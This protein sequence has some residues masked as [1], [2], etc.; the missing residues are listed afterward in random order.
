LAN[1]SVIPNTNNCYQLTADLKKQVGVVWSTNR[2]DVSCSFTLNAAMYFGTHDGVNNKT[3]S[4][5]DGIAFVL[6][7]QG[8]GAVG[9][10][11]GG[12][13]WSGIRPSIGVAFDT[14]QNDVTSGDPPGDYF[15]LIR[16]GKVVNGRL[17]APSEL[18]FNIEDGQYHDVKFEWIS[19]IQTVRITFDGSVV[20]TKSAIN[21]T[22]YLG[23]KN[24]A[25]LGF[26]A[27]T[28]E[29]SN[30][31]AVCI[32]SFE[33]FFHEST[34]APSS[35][36]PVVH[37]S[38]LFHSDA[39]P[40]TATLPTSPPTTTDSTSYMPHVS[41]ALSAGT[42]PWKE[43]PVSPILNSA[44]SNAPSS[45]TVTPTVQSTPPSSSTPNCKHHTPYSIGT[46]H[47]STRWRHLD[48][49]DC[50][51]EYGNDGSSGGDESMNAGAGGSNNKPPDGVPEDSFLLLVSSSTTAEA[52]QYC[53]LLW[54]VLQF[55]F[56][57]FS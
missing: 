22:S 8:P 43:L 41:P 48:V 52:R 13:G 19:S 53:W 23:N 51:K 11:G 26:T 49:E 28:G 20:L 35:A 50:D 2:V 17:T 47:Q 12:M 29:A 18:G 56:F 21:L 54:L 10:V 5:A 57:L 15:A 45:I 27:S 7:N 55:G 37:S 14:Y 16:D 39:A 1:C 32:K 30:R 6:Q 31:Q 33:S 25:Y 9:F 40:F 42:A 46:V 34:T 3:N 36:I 24:S 44:P 4:G 38:P